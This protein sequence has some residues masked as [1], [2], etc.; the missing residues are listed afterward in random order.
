MHP[1]LPHS[2]TRKSAF[3]PLLRGYHIMYRTNEHNHCPGCGHSHWIVGRTVA[4]CA[5]CST[6]LPLDIH[7]GGLGGQP[8]FTEAGSSNYML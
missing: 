6:A 4:E 7:A 5:F 8:R 3:N 1:N 2:T